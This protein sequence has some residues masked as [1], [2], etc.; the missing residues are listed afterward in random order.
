MCVILIIII[1]P[2]LTEMLKL[3]SVEDCISSYHH[4]LARGV[5]S[6]EVLNFKK[7]TWHFFHCYRGSDV[8]N[9]ENSIL[10]NAKDA[11]R[12]EVILFKRKTSWTFLSI[13]SNKPFKF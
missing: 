5:Y 7:A 13:E 10:K 1:A 3:S 4:H 11:I 9:N 8:H 2:V 6:T 12:F